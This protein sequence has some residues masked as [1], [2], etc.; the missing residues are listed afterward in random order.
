MSNKCF[1][2]NQEEHPMLAYC[3]NCQGEL[4][5][6]EIEF[7]TNLKDMINSGRHHTDIKTL[8]NQRIKGLEKK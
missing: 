3:Q 5:V 1:C 8:I 6:N 7:L 2:Q 4:A